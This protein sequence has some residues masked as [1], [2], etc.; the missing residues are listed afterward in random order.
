[1][2]EQENIISSTFF[3]AYDA[4]WSEIGLPFIYDNTF[5]ECLR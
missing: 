5:N 3:A 4:I 2:Q 1:M